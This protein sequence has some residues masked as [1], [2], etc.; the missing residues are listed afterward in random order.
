MEPAYICIGHIG[1]PFGYDG[2]VQVVP[3]TDFPQRFE[4]T[5]RIFVRQPGGE[6]CV[7][8]ITQ[9]QVQNGR[10]TLKFAGLD[11]REAVLAWQGADIE[12]GREEVE[13]LPDGSWYIF[14]LIDAEVN[15]PTHGT[16]GRVTD[17]LR[18][19]SN[20]ILV[21]DAHGREVLIPMIGTVIK[22]VDIAAKRI[23]INVIKGL[24][25]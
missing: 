4:R 23:E 16:I 15:S 13:P 1:R 2:R 14:D 11:S 19:A 9:A 6:R 20:D 18:L 8:T 3:R 24:L 5:A 12:V 7:F 25:D 21:V 10:V 22:H 17:V